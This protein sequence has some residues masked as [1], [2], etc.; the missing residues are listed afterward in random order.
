MKKLLYLL[1]LFLIW[2]C[3]DDEETI[4]IDNNSFTTYPKG[5]FVATTTG[6]DTIKLEYQNN[7][8]TKRI[9]EWME[10]AGSTGY[11]NKFSKLIETQITYSGNQAILNKISKME[12]YTPKDLLTYNLNGKQILEGIFTYENKP[13]YTEKYVYTYE[14]SQI[15]HIDLLV[16]DNNY[17]NDLRSR[18]D[19]YFSKNG[20]L[21]SLVY[22][23]S[24]HDY[25]DIVPPFID[26]KIKKRNVTTFSNYDQSQNPFQNLSLFLD[27]YYKSLSKNNFRKMETIQ[28]D[29]EGKPSLGIST[30]TWDYEY[31]NGEVKVLK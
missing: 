14:N 19:F 26:Y 12:G 16:S 10:L 22:R 30:S 1:P 13:N 7:Q 23:E 31:I 29:E 8:V 2:S 20:N 11:D 18:R 28:Y 25:N 27:L 6:M 15:K 4:P 3:N 24:T 9:G 17:K 21:D 5:Y